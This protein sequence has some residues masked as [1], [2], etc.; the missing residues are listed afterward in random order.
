MVADDLGLERR[1]VEV[2]P[3]A[4]RTAR[5]VV[6]DR[7]ARPLVQ[8]QRPPCAHRDRIAG[9]EVNEPEDGPAA[10]ERQ[11]EPAASGVGPRTGLM[12]NDGTL[13]HL[14][15]LEAHAEREGVC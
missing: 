13:L 14:G 2:Q 9:P 3:Y 8:R 12:K 10:I 4:G 5:S 1:A 15:R 7:E 6:R 11:L